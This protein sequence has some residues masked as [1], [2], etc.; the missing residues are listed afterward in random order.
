[1]VP[2]HVC[3]GTP[4][5]SP[6]CFL[7]VQQALA[8]KEAEKIAAL[9]AKDAEIA[10]AARLHADNLERA[11]AQ[12]DREINE[13]MELAQAEVDRCVSSQWHSRAFFHPVFFKLILQLSCR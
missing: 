2:N 9:A 13:A 7:P 5:F 12:K 3:I 8:A 11:M 10:S 6:Q 1:M 4:R